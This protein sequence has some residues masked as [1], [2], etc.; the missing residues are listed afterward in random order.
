LIILNIFTCSIDAGYFSVLKKVLKV[1]IIRQAGFKIEKLY[2]DCIDDRG[3]CFILYWAKVKFFLL[4][5]IYSGLVFSDADGLTIE[6]S[7]LRK[8][9]KPVINGGINFKNKFLKTSVSLKRIDDPITRSLYK[10]N[11]NNELIWNCHHPKALAEINYNGRIYKG[12]GYSETLFCP[13]NPLK[14]PMEELKWGRFLSDSH[15]VIWINW[16]D[17]QPLNKI[18]MNGT[19]YND[20]VFNNETIYFNDGKYKLTFSEIRSI[21]NNKLSRLFSKMKFMKIFFKSRL[22]N[23]LEKKYKAKTILSENSL[24]LSDGWSLFET[25]T[26]RK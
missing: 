4:R 12:Y 13:I 3:N 9:I 14:L 6:K 22:L 19:E 8:T 23:S 26:W 15:T 25:V 2:I 16:K 11:E 18:F 20:A 5:I 24:F 7:T 21:R 17:D 1:F 10:E